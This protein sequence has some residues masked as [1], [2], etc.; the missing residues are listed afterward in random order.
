MKITH[1]V[2]G[3]YRYTDN[4]TCPCG[5]DNRKGKFATEKGYAGQPVGHCH[6][7][8]K[9]FWAD[10]D[11][12]I[13]Q[14][15]A[16]V[17]PVE[18]CRPQTQDLEGSF[19]Y[20]LSSG[21]AQFLIETFGIEKATEAVEKY[22]L[23]VYDSTDGV[24]HKHPS[25]IFWQIDQESELRC[26]KIITYKDDG[27]RDKAI[28]PNWW[29]SINKRDCQVHQCFFGE[30]LIPDYDLPIAV[31]E[32]AKTAI[33]M[34]IVN[35]SFIWI[36]SEG[37]TNLTDNKCHSIYAYDVTLFP[38]AGWYDG[39]QSNRKYWKPIAEKFEFE[40]SR[41]CE[42]WEEQGLINDGDDIADYFLRMPAKVKLPPDIDIVKVDTEWNQ[43]EYD[44]IFKNNE[45]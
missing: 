40:I 7:C 3:K 6:S 45:R 43:K 22:Y 42:L 16:D 5:L 31:V 11:F 24:D 23:G 39:A 10:S 12:K 38:D 18:F 14:R 32:A 25:T 13:E 33:I 28:N 26:G 8:A 19:D 15:V 4:R 20:D 1:R 30:H 34:S 9:D 44:D 21:F 37:A 36:S 29:H 41:E 35:P 2:F 27:H 17:K